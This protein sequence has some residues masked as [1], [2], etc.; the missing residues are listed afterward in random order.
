MDIV[1][2]HAVTARALG[3]D[4]AAVPENP[5]W[6][7]LDRLE[8]ITHLHE[9]LGD[10]VNRIENL[11]SFVDLETLAALLKENGLVD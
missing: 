2:L 11:E 9:V 6:D 10:D 8:I 4:P 3:K 1:E 7:S 5:E